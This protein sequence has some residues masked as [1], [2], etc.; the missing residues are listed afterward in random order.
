[1]SPFF[2]FIQITQA[3]LLYTHNFAIFRVLFLCTI[4]HGVNLDLKV[5]TKLLFLPWI[6]ILTR[7]FEHVNLRRV[8]CR[9]Q[10]LFCINTKPKCEFLHDKRVA[11]CR[12]SG[13]LFSKVHTLQTTIIVFKPKAPI[14]R[15]YNKTDSHKSNEIRIKMKTTIFLFTCT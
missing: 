14:K 5:Y 13:F 3:Q 2:S 12:Q 8:K 11:I 9:V 15:I 1:M 7:P 4:L 10:K 6:W